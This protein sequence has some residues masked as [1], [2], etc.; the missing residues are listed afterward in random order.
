MKSQLTVTIAELDLRASIVAQELDEHLQ[1]AVDQ[2]IDLF[3]RLVDKTRRE[4]GQRP[5]EPQAGIWH[6]F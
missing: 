5:F 4:V 2:A 1:G 6:D 3:R